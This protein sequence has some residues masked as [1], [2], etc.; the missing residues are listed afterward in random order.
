M[1]VIGAKSF[2]TAKRTASHLRDE[3]NNLCMET[4]LASQ[5]I[6][7]RLV[8]ANSGMQE[9]SATMSQMRM[10]FVPQKAEN[11]YDY[12]I[13][14]KYFEAMLHQAVRF[15]LEKGY[16]SASLP[17]GIEDGDAQLFSLTEQGIKYLE[18]Q[19]ALQPEPVVFSD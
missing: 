11:E 6:L 17:D 9:G 10:W 12:S 5:V 3:N 15:L 19:A 4:E 18:Q 14:E 8:S 7:S 13:N 2:T 16:L 1:A